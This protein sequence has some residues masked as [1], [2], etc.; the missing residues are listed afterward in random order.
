MKRLLVLVPLTSGCAE[1][2]LSS[3]VVEVDTAA[4]SDTDTDTD[5]DTDTDTDSDVDTDTTPPDTT[6]TDTTP[7]DTDTTPVTT[8]TGT[9]PVV[10]GPCDVPVPD[11]VDLTDVVWAMPNVHFYVPD[12]GWAFASA[13]ASRE[14]ETLS[15]DLRLPPSYFLATALKESFMGCS[16]TI[17]PDSLHGTLWDRQVIADATGCMQFDGPGS[18]WL[19]MCGMYPNEIDCGVVDF[20]DVIPSTNQAVT[21]RDNVEPSMLVAAYYAVFA[22]AMIDKNHGANPDTWFAA[23]SDPQAMLKTMTVL[24]NT[25]AWSWDV[26]QI[27]NGCQLQNIE[28]CMNPLTG[29]YDYVVAIS[30]YAADMEAAVVASSCYDEDVTVADVHD[31]LDAMEPLFPNENWAGIKTDAET[32]FLAASGGAP[33]ARFQTVADAVLTA[34]DG[35]IGTDLNCPAAELAT[36]YQTTCP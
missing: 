3:K 30:S 12:P 23:A 31:W 11:H 32:A 17:R 13:F 21:G 15:M 26:T 8:D 18:A 9:P 5:A 6:D 34:A 20:Y 27:I 14:L 24:Y 19:E 4:E 2:Y 16:D 1:Y 29:A 28:S 33:T 7:L 10:P 36:R 22:Y 25:G 35:G